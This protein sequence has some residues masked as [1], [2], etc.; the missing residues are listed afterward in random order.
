MSTDEPQTT[1]CKEPNR[2][3]VYVPVYNAERYL[4]GCLKGIQAQ[5]H[6]VDEIVVVDDGSTDGSAD[7]ARRCGAR[8]IAQSTNLGLSQARRRAFAEIQTP[9]IAALDADC[10]PEPDWLDTLMPDFENPSIG[11]TS[12]KLIEFHADC[13]VDRWRKV[14]MVQHWGDRRMNAPLHLFGNNTVFRRDAVLEAGNY[15]EGAEYRTNNEDYYMTRRLRE[16]GYHIIY[17]PQAIVYHHRRDSV[18]SLF[19]TYW[20]W[21]FLHRPRPDSLR[22]LWQKA[23]DNASRSV[24]FMKK[25]VRT[26][27]RHLFTLDLLFFLEQSRLDFRYYLKVSSKSN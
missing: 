26:R 17:N 4:E 18:E 9:F 10:I 11:G 5:T 14:H 21:F 6:P 19:R 12:G 16:R 22:G 20:N 13:P 23:R 27:D 24:E 7:I 8:I 2:V 1:V 3:T 25:D 15:P